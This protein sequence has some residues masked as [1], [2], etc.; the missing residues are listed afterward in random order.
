MQHEV[1]NFLQKGQG[2]TE[3]EVVERPNPNFTLSRVASLLYG[4]EGACD[5][6]AQ[7]TLPGPGTELG[8]TQGEGGGRRG[9]KAKW[10]G[11]EDE[12][13]QLAAMPELSA[14]EWGDEFRAIL[15]EWDKG[16][17]CAIC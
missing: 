3:L 7:Y 11:T 16:D 10:K 12:L 1:D 17:F 9:V 5:N 8:E 15:S 2:G 14:F 4:M 6:P 13:R